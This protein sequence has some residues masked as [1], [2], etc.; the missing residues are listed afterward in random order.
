MGQ[1]LEARKMASS[2]RQVYA[3]LLPRAE[4]ERGWVAPVT[5]TILLSLIAVLRSEGDLAGIARV[6]AARAARPRTSP[7]MEG[8][9]PF[10]PDHLMED[11]L[12]YAGLA[13]E[14]GDLA[15][16]RVWYLDLLEQ[17]TREAPCDD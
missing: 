2:A 1:V 14:N 15:T 3:E 9:V 13:H 10:R 6:H 4:K 16:A 8:T 7:Y 12:N 11:A 17:V 5:I